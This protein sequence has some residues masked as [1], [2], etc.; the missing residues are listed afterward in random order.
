MDAKEIRSRLRSTL[1]ELGTYGCLH[2]LLQLVDDCDAPVR[3]KSIQLLRRLRDILATYQS[4]DLNVLQGTHSII[5]QPSE[6]MAEEN[7]TPENETGQRDSDQVIEEILS[8][9]D[10]SLVAGIL[11]KNDPKQRPDPKPVSSVSAQDFV[12][13]VNMMELETMLESTWMSSDLHV[14]DFDSLIDDL[15]D[16]IHTDT[17]RPRPDCY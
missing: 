5:N 14:M 7:F 4:L 13:K 11:A 12:N 1:S 3:E 16:C 9:N 2:V 10:S 6:P 8:V 17:S 15:Q